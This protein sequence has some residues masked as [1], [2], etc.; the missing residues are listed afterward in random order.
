M[1]KLNSP[2]LFSVASYHSGKGVRL[3]LTGRGFNPNHVAPPSVEA[4]RRPSTTT[5]LKRALSLNKKNRHNL[6]RYKQTV[7]EQY[8]VIFIN[9]LCFIKDSKGFKFYLRE[10]PE[11][12]KTIWIIFYTAIYWLLYHGG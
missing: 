12:Q 6:K 8:E 9:A 1:Y 3:V 4:I 2:L 10:I 7:I 11:G 5:A